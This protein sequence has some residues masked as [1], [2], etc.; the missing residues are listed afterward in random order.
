MPSYDEIPRRHPVL[1]DAEERRHRPRWA[2]RLRRR[3]A[4]PLDVAILGFAVVCVV[5]VGGAGIWS[6]LG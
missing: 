2:I 1:D 6:L 3:F 4:S 5:A